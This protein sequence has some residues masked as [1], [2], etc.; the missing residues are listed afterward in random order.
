MLFGFVP[1][2]RAMDK[3]SADNLQAAIRTLSFLE[4]LP[5]EGVIAVGVVYPSDIPNAQALA[6]ETAKSI[7]DMRGPNSRPLQAV[8]L[9]TIELGTFSGHLDVIFLM[10]GASKDSELILDAMRR[11]QLMS[12]SGD[13]ACADAR[14][15]VLM[16]RSGQR[17]EISLNTALAEAVG[18][19]FSLVFTMVVKRR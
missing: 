6:L 5:R 7:G 19:R 9:S 15:C 10:P 14:C 16:V 1:P 3:V 13:P 2:M 11:H 18:A 17:V 12:I 4:S 8:A